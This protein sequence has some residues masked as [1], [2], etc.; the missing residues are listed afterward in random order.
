ML[1]P[2]CTDFKLGTN[3]NRGS[4]R[5]TS[6]YEIR[7]DSPSV[8]ATTRPGP[9]RPKLGYALFGFIRIAK[10]IRENIE[11][12]LSKFLHAFQRTC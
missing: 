11:K 10:K 6:M 8:L 5:L 1:H 9:S 4:A 2:S 12:K 7:Q 3:P